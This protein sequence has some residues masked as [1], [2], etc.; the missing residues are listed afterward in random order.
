MAIFARIWAFFKAVFAESVWAPGALEDEEPKYRNARRIWLP[1][2]DLIAIYVGTTGIIFGSP[3]LRRLFPEEV[4][5][6]STGIFLFA[7]M[8]CLGGVLFARLWL[9][10]MLGKLTLFGMI[11]A[12]ITTILLNPSTGDPNWFVVGMIALGIPI[13]LFRLDVLTYEY[14]ERK[15][16]EEAEKLLAE[17]VI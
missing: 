1:L 10:E 11:V 16:Q 17:G 15:E 3:I 8:L 12:Y 6:I 14:R 2:Y 4:I 7:A 13:C 9:V 5:D